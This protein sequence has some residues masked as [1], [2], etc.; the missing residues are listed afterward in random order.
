MPSWFCFLRWTFSA[1]LFA[2]IFALVPSA[3]A[4]P[5]YKVL[6]AFGAGKDG[7]ILWGSLTLD[8]KGN[9]YGTTAGGGAH[10][11]GTVF[12]LTPKP[13]GRWEETILYS[14]RDPYKSDDG[15]TPSASLVFDDAGHLFGTTPVG[16][17]SYTDGTVFELS[18]GTHNWSETE[19]HRFGRNDKASGPWGGVIR[20]S[21]GNLYGVGGCAF[22]LSSEAG[23]RRREHILHCF[24]AFDGDGWEELDR[25]ILNPA[26]NLYG[27]T[28]KG[29]SYRAGTVYELRLTSG[30]WKERILHSFPDFSSDGQVPGVGA[31]VLDSA[32]TL[33]G[34]TAQ[35][36]SN[37]C[38]DVGCGTVFK[39]T[40]EANG[41]WKETILHNFAAGSSGNGPGAGVVLDQAGILYGTTIYGGTQCGCGVVYKLAPQASGK[42]KYTV[43]HTFVGS[44]GAQPDANLILDDKGNLYG[45][46]A[47]GGTA[48]AGVAF[49]LTP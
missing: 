22:E 6:H 40:P 11:Y 15:G 31:L 23:G 46:T 10:G 30:G 49:E 4:T 33:Y 42:W 32:G 19:I 9:L 8:G 37:T 16:G 45:T 20:D 17:G 29:G 27:T 36:G 2:V 26:G 18:R 3:S 48:G 25:P 7:T 12:Q 5:R 38:G 28:E 14:F 21:S 35:G 39:L 43:L 1:V 44:D 47:V 13:D 24:P 34:T 41:E